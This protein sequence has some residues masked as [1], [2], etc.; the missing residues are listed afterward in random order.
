MSDAQII[1]MIRE[2]IKELKANNRE[3]DKLI[4]KLYVIVG[5]LTVRSTIINS[6]FG[7]IGG[8]LAIIL[9]KYVFKAF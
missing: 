2:D 4:N 1:A 7:T 6:V 5:K 9:L 3:Q 8:G